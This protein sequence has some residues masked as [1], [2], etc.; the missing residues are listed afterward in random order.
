MSTVLTRNT[1]SASTPGQT[2]EDTRACGRTGKGKGEASMC[3]RQ[4]NRAKVSGTR[5]KGLSGWKPQVEF[6][7]NVLMINMNNLFDNNNLFDWEIIII[8]SIGK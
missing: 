1:G 5:T 3:W 2:E 4:A 6:N 8:Y 7:E